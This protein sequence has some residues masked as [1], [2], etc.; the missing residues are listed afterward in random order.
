M[1]THSQNC[2]GKLLGERAKAVTLNF[3]IIGH[4]WCHDEIPNTKPF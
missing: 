2:P 1:K 4:L 3:A